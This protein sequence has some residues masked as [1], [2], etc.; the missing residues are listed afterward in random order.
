MPALYLR[1]VR[2]H[3]GLTGQGLQV[4]RTEVP[5]VAEDSQGLITVTVEGAQPSFKVRR[6]LILV[7]SIWTT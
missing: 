5:E 7:R 6:E 4:L 1:G 3:T 2:G